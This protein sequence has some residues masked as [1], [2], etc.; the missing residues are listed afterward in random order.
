[1]S[2][3][4]KRCTGLSEGLAWSLLGEGSW[5]PGNRGAG[6]MEATQQYCIPLCKDSGAVGMAPM[7]KVSWSLPRAAP[8]AQE[9]R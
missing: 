1:M 7:E 5:G 9:Q 8:H 2:L 6:W 4:Y 3:K